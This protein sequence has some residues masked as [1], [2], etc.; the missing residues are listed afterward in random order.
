MGKL[1]EY[2]SEKYAIEN[3]D[4]VNR[5]L[6]ELSSLFE[7]S[8]TLN[9]SLN[10]KAILD[11]VL[12]IPMGRMMISRGMILLNENNRFVLANQKG[13]IRWDK[14][15]IEITNVNIETIVDHP[16]IQ[17]IRKTLQFPVVIPL[18]SARELTGLLFLGKKLNGEPFSTEEINFLESLASIAAT[19]IQNARRLQQV[20]AMNIQLQE[21][22]D[23]LATVLKVSQEFLVTFEEKDILFRLLEALI[24][25]VQIEDYAIYIHRDQILTLE[26]Q[27]TRQH[28]IDR[29]PLTI[30]LQISEVT[31]TNDLD[32]SADVDWLTPFK[33]II[34]L[35]FQDTPV[36]LIL[37]G[38]PRSKPDYQKSDVYFF[39]TLA[40]QAS[41]A[42]HN[43]RLFQ[44][45]L[46]KERLEREMS[47]AREIQLKLLP[48]S[49]PNIKGF[50]F[51]GKNLPSRTVGG[52]YY[53]VIPLNDGRIAFAIGDVTGKGIPAAML[54]A[55]LQAALHL[56]IHENLPLSR[57]AEKLNI[58]F[59]NNTTPDK[60]VTLFL[61][62][63]HP[64]TRTISYVNAGH[65]YPLF[66][67]PDG[68]LMEL[69]TGGLLMGA[70]PFARYE[71]AQIT[72]PP[73]SL[74]F[75]YTDGVTELTNP[76]GEEFGEKRLQS[77]L[78][79]HRNLPAEQ[80]IH[81][82][83]TLLFEFSGNHL[84]EDD[85]TLLLVQ[86]RDERP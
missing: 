17:T 19:S 65:N 41:I 38:A 42:L 75:S 71:E 12:L 58:L 78:I 18:Q 33:L 40:N 10:L 16:E 25:I 51:A 82:L 53:D 22:V 3:L 27:L 43:A 45:T 20:E 26:K 56:L 31:C 49:L 62:I 76:R 21:K 24:S 77:F 70:F 80:I 39:Q 1:I 84:F 35:K 55:N 11:N 32:F 73:G 15:F 74:L 23:Q 52:D 37:L 86:A 50:Q 72:L 59:Y 2:L 47:M 69:T 66:L 34:P 83:N 29:L 8:Q 36:A 54:M 7:I 79:S 85:V 4:E 67:S 48:T 13:I 63:L 46:E 57:I 64:Q 5:R 14:P 60:F 9:R 6:L 44:Q 30:N 28:L 68:E 61:G 81:K